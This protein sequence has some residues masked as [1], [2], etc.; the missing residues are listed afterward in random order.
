MPE[1]MRIFWSHI[2]VNAQ[3][4]MSLHATYDNKMEMGKVKGGLVAFKELENMMKGKTVTPNAY[5]TKD[6]EI[7][8]VHRDP[9]TG[10]IDSIS[11]N[12]GPRMVV[13]VELTDEGLFLY[14]FDNLRGCRPMVKE[15]AE[16]IKLET[17][18][19]TMTITPNNKC[20]A[21]TYH[22]VLPV[23]MRDSHLD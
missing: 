22:L 20:G 16:L 15:I 4:V 1:K 10:G 8:E 19:E 18:C 9:Y 17:K 21:L 2:C 13:M 23:D 12:E 11:Y 6:P 3:G 14:E 5:V 7:K